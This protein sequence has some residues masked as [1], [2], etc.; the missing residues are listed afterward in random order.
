[1][2]DDLASRVLVLNL[3]AP[4]RGLGEWLTSAASLGVP[5]YVTLHQL[6]TMPLTMPGM[7]VHV[8]ENPA[9]LRRAAA[10]LGGGSAA[11]LCTE[12]R[13]STAFNQLA[14]AIVVGGGEL[15]Y[16]GDF[17]WPGISIANSVM[18]RHDARPWRMSTADYLEGTRTD[19]EYVSLTGTPQATPWDPALRE[20]MTT[21]GRAVYEESVCAPLIED[22]RDTA[23]VRTPA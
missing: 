1:M 10:E 21:K 17:D 2:L 23:Q 19:A 8:C 16:H 20:A 9:I 11:L 13:P 12:G 5:F 6:M 22:L 14:T 18:I 4:G 3:P 15:S 7:L